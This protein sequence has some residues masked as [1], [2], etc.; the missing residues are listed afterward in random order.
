LLIFL[1]LLSWDDLSLIRPATAVGYIVSLV[2]AKYFLGERIN[3]GRLI[4]IGVIAVGIFSLSV[5]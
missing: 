2:F 3:K 5:Y 4:G 1:A